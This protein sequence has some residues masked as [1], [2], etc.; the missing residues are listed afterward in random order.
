MELLEES[1]NQ[2]VQIL[3]G[4]YK[5]YKGLVLDVSEHSVRVELEANENIAILPLQTTLF[6]I[7]HLT[8][9]VLL[10]LTSLTI[11][12]EENEVAL[13]QL[14]EEPSERSQN[15]NT[16]DICVPLPAIHKSESEIRDQLA[17]ELNG[18]TEVPMGRYGRVDVATDT[19]IIE[20]QCLRNYKHALGQILVYGL[21]EPVKKKR[22]HLFRSSEDEEISRSFFLDIFN[23]FSVELTFAD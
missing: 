6:K 4:P 13:P 19:E 12:D 10:E 23:K 5:G 3:S 7:E 8:V 16:A 20:V 18:R 21:H 22:V 14:A 9:R 15:P 1:Q 17:A 2:R 11:E